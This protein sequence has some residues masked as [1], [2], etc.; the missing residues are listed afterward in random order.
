MN[1]FI[2]ALLASL[3]ASNV[4]AQENPPKLLL[5]ITIPCGNDGYKY[6]DDLTKDFKE[7][8]FAQGFFSIKPA[9]GNGFVKSKFYMYVS[10]DWKTFSIFSL[11]EV[12]DL[13]LPVA[14]ILVGGEQLKPYSLGA[15]RTSLGVK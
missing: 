6:I 13:S 7:L 12:E 1:R 8:P 11:T 15:F 2:I 9:I 10:K 5:D 14:C 4:S 3:I